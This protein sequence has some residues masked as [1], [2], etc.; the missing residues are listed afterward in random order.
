MATA[1]VQNDHEIKSGGEGRNKG[2]CVVY[3]PSPVSRGLEECSGWVEEHF[4]KDYVND[5]GRLSN[6]ISPN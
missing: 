4:F 2:K 1:S 5:E 6:K 3:D